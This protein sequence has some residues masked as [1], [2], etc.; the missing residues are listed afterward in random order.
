MLDK[1]KSLWARL[2]VR[3]H[4]IV[5]ALIAAL[6]GILDWLAVIDL[7]PILEHFVSPE[8]RRRSSLA[9]CPSS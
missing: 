4:V 5:L 1:I 3:W 2:Q 7:K 9:V 8:H 6:P